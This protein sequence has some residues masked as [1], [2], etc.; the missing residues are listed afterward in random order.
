MPEKPPILLLQSKTDEFTGIHSVNFRI[1][2]DEWEYEFLTGDEYLRCLYLAVHSPAKA[3]NYAKKWC[4]KS[5]EVINPH[6]CI[7]CNKEFPT[8]FGL[9]TVCGCCE[10]CCVCNE[11]E[12]S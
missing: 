1:R 12:V 3:L 10:N 5:R 11:G 2:G 6:A 7:G 4:M 8:G 9:C